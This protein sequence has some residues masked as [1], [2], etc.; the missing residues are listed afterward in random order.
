MWGRRRSSGRG[1]GSLLRSEEDYR[2]GAKAA[3]ED[4]SFKTKRGDAEVA[5][6][7]AEKIEM[8]LI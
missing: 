1:G 5:E 3:K 8:D 7:N 6:E 2:K 4:L